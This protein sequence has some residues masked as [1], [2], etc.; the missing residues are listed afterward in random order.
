MTY[1]HF[2]HDLQTLENLSSKTFISTKSVQTDNLLFV[3]SFFFYAQIC[4]YGEK[5]LHD[6]Y[7][8][9]YYN[10]LLPSDH[11]IDKMSVSHT[12]EVWK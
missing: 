3:I 7:F 10:F 11:A 6:M 9:S 2:L 8:C 1:R 12:N 4:P 5:K